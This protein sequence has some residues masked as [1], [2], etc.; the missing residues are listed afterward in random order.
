MVSTLLTWW[1]LMASGLAAAP[2][3]RVAA[4]AAAR[5]ERASFVS[6][7]LGQPREL[8]VV[9]PP[10]YDPDA[11]VAYPVVYLLHGLGGEPQ[12]WV[13]HGKI[14]A[15]LG[16]LVAAGGVRPL[17]LVAPDG[18]N[19]YWTDHLGAPG[20][21]GPRWGS[22]VAE[23]V[24]REVEARYRVR[25]DRAGRAIAG[26]SMGGHGAMSIGLVHPERFAAIVSLAGALFPE[27]P[28]HRPVYKKVWGD[29]PDAAHWAATSPMAL[30][31]R[32]DPGPA[33]PALYLHCGDDDAAG[34]LEYAVDA[35]RVLLERKVPH[36]L[37]VGD[38]GHVWGAW[39]TATEDWL[40]F[41]D[42]GLGR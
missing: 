25:R 6:R 5:V 23:D 24:V 35:H 18:D 28:T 20:A 10:G 40:R 8:L 39:N 15:V 26:V 22:Y 33:T 29:P 31:R 21:P 3:P 30:M 4:P 42:A 17:V 34:F 32:L 1:A 37:R 12:D 36:E 16:R 27:P 2:A 7:A 41:V 11:P 19:G 38:G 14:D 13:T 9:L